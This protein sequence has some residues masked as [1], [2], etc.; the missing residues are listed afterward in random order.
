MI[1]FDLFNSSD[2]YAYPGDEYVDVL[3]LDNC[4]AASAN[5][6]DFKLML[7]NLQRVAVER[8]RFAVGPQPPDR[9]PARRSRDLA[10]RC[11]SE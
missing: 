2:F 8:L 9:E 6:D 5:Q 1:I 3:G 10:R 7:G 11:E 4:I